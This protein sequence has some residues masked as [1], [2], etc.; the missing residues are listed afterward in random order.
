MKNLFRNGHVI[1]ERQSTGPVMPES[2]KQLYDNLDKETV[3]YKRILLLPEVQEDFSLSIKFMT[4]AGISDG[5]YGIS[6]AR[7]KEITVIAKSRGERL[8]KL[9]Q[10]ILMGLSMQ[11]KTE[12]E[13]K[14]EIKER[15]RQRNDQQHKYLEIMEYYK[16][17][18][19]KSF[20]FIWCVICLTCGLGL[21]VADFPLA[22][23]LFVNGFNLRPLE[24]YFMAGGVCLCSIFIKIYYDNYVDTKFGS[25]L[26]T[27]SKYAEMFMNVTQIEPN[28]DKVKFSAS[29][30]KE[31][32]IKRRWHNAILV[33]T[34]IVIITLGIFRVE[35]SPVSRVPYLVNLITFIFL[36][37]IFPVISGV[38]L[39]IGLT[40]FQN[41][42]VYW[43]TGWKCNK[44]EGK[45]IGALKEYTASQRNKEDIDNE[46]VKWNNPPFVDSYKDILLSYYDHGYKMGAV[47]PDV[48]LKGK[49]L[50]S[51]AAEWREKAISRKINNQIAK[52]SGI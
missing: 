31:S 30:E 21:F 8:M 3:Y 16:R 10:S 4:D 46:L 52:L 18:H 51:I 13:E 9:A 25:H 40:V 44:T 49:D 45:Y 29:L 48:T 37:L 27:N 12:E 47:H 35:A 14:R 50:Y 36:T 26:L 23:I 5:L 22:R 28:L 6:S 7:E 24:G 20:S 41:K 19:P 33:F 11:A 2:I 39:S 17:H 42:L 32:R 1:N 43:R 38:C 34:L 15:D